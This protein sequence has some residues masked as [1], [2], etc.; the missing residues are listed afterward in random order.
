MA[1]ASGIG[2]L[3]DSVQPF[4]LAESFFGEDQGLYVV[5]VC[6]QCMADFM[7]DAERADVP[8]DLLGRT[9]KDRLVFETENGDYAVTLD[10]LR[11][12]HEGFFPKLMQ[13]EVA[14]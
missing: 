6:D 4:G 13:G 1:L 7:A 5:T 8:A 2:A 11:S 14:A 12:A 9:I 3:I 10:A